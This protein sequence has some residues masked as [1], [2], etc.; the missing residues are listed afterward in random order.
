[1]SFPQWVQ[2]QAN[3]ETPVNEAFAILTP[4]AVYGRDPDTTSDLDWGYLGGIWSGFTVAADVLSLTDDATNYMVVARADG[5]PTVS[6]ATTNWDNDTSYA[7]V[8][9]ITTVDGVVT[10]V[11]DHRVGGAGIFGSGTGGGGGGGTIGKQSIYVS[12]AAMSPSASGGC[13]ALATVATS[14]NQP[15]LQTLNFDASSQEFAQFSA[16]LP[17]KWN[18]GTVTFKAHWSHPSTTTNFGVAWQLQAVAVGNDDA[19]AT[20]YGTEQ[21]VTDTGGTTNDLYSTAESSAITVGGTP[22]AEDMVFFRVAR[23]PSDGGDTLA[24]DARLHG[25]TL[26]VTTDAETDA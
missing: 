22:A 5:T 7:R 13:A 8:C 15:D 10:D 14:A 9:A 1:M 17:K 26:Y 24:V 2:G 25:I 3:P 12:A 11:E 19:I 18:R 16:V 4:L 21:L 23:T 20:A 6:T